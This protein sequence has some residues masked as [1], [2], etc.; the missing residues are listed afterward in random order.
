MAY[1]FLFFL[2]I[3]KLKKGDYMIDVVKIQKLDENLIIIMPT[4]ICQKL[5]LEEG[6]QIEME[7][8]ICGGENGVRIRKR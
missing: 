5:N 1:I 4:E 6:S 7:H 2:T 8:F 3:K